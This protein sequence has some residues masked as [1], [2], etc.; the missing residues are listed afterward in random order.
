VTKAIEMASPLLE[1]R[2]HALE[3]GVPRHGLRLKVD[4][5]RIAQVLANLLTNAAKYTDEG[6]EITVRAAEEDDQ[7][8]FRV[9]DN[10]IGIRTELLPHVFGLFV[11]GDRTLDRGEGGLGLGLTLVRTLVTLHEGT[12]EA[13]SDGPGRGSEFVVR[14]PLALAESTEAPVEVAA[15]RITMEVPP[16][17]RRVMVVDDNVDAADTLAEVVRMWGH[18][19]RMAHD[20]PSALAIV[21]SGFVPDVALLD[22]GLPVMDGYELAARLRAVVDGPLRLVAVTGYGQD[23]DRKRAHEAGFDDHL[24]KPIDLE[25]LRGSLGSLDP[26]TATVGSTP[27]VL[28]A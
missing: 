27:N 17:V 8:V 2:R 4:P 23:S 12:V 3:L 1:R 19:V 10:G 5:T 14:L 15:A 16:L 28:S 24:V 13:H 11:Q 6:G 21:D 26:T 22:I 9:R 18:E 20:G 25:R 7:V